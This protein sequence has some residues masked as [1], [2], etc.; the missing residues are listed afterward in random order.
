MAEG[1]VTLP[2]MDK[3]RG[4]KDLGA[5]GHEEALQML[6]KLEIFIEPQHWLFNCGKLLI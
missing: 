5:H 2:E 6:P 1:K 3:I 4:V